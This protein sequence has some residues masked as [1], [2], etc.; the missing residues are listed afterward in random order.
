[1]KVYIQA[2]PVPN[3]LQEVAAEF[4][5]IEVGEEAP[6]SPFDMVVVVGETMTEKEVMAGL[7]RDAEIPTSWQRRR[8]LSTENVL[9]GE[10][11]QLEGRWYVL[12]AEPEKVSITFCRDDGRIYTQIALPDC[13]VACPESFL[14]EP[15]LIGV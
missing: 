5:H 15:N 6:T 10:L 13:W 1:M 14:A 3:W 2:R 7:A 8:D 4:S 9:A 12:N 11:Q